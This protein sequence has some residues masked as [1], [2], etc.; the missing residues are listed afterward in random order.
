MEETT[1]ESGCKGQMKSGTTMSGQRQRRRQ[2]GEDE[3]RKCDGVMPA[4]AIFPLLPNL[5]NFEARLSTGRTTLR[6]AIQACGGQKT[7]DY[8]R[9]QKGGG[10]LR[11]ILKG[12]DPNAYN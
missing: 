2:A 10:I 11:G 4:E 3:T 1:R 5:W 9:F 6:D 12:R 7:A 8:R